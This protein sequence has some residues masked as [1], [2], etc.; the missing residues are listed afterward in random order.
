ML[1]PLGLHT[2]FTNMQVDF[3]PLLIAMEN[4]MRFISLRKAEIALLLALLLSGTAHAAD[5]PMTLAGAKNTA[6]DEI[7]KLQAAGAPVF[8]VR[9]ASEYADAHIKGAINV[10]YREKSE[11]AV[12]FDAGQ[13][14]FN[15]A[16][17]PADKSV[18]LVI[19]CNGPEC[20]KSYKASVGAIK[21]GYTNIHWYREGFP[22]WKAKGL[23]TE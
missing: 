10:P 13:D 15:I 20:W 12:S 8:D 2:L 1:F 23:P 18:A 7:V 16:K 14:E 5:T 17:L 4:K 11:K 3:L 19:Y 22:D 21:A 6:A 9:V